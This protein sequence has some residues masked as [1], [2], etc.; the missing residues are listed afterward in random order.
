M[1][2]AIVEF[3]ACRHTPVVGGDRQ[4]V[5]ELIG[6]RETKIDQTAQ[7]VAIK[8]Q[9]VVA[10]Q[11][12]MN[13]AI[14]QSGLPALTLELE[15]RFDQGVLFRADN[16]RTARD[17][18]SV[19]PGPALLLMRVRKA[20][21]ALCNRPSSRPTARNATPWLHHRAPGNALRQR[22]RTAVEDRKQRSGTIGKPASAPRLRTAPDVP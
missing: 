22:C 5:G 16:G 1:Q 7:R 11:I 3:T 12:G 17:V 14:G 20:R 19:Q 13:R 21:L 18:D 15:P 4:I 6:R 8:Q 9:Y 2:P 10:K